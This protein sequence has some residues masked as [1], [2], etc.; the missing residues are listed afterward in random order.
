MQIE[1]EELAPEIKNEGNTAAAEPFDQWKAQGFSTQ[2]IYPGVKRLSMISLIFLGVTAA[3]LA[4]PLLVPY[5]EEECTPGFYEKNKVPGSLFN[6][7]H[8]NICGSCE[9]P[10]CASC[11][12]S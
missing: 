6:F 7:M 12:A 1:E 5:L 2:T 10:F 3:S 11:E 4:L 8:E 9:A